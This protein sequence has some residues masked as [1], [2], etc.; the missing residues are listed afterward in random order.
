MFVLFLCV[1][2]PVILKELKQADGDFTEDQRIE[3]N[4]VRHLCVIPQTSYKLIWTLISWTQS[5]PLFN[6]LWVHLNH[7]P[8]AS[9]VVLS[10]LL[11]EEA[12][13]SCVFALH[14]ILF[15]VNLH[16]PLPTEF[17]MEIDDAILV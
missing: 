8:C 17:S 11:H 2:Q 6:L 15:H 12:E 10:C 5:T 4:T 3:L 1:F 14:L 16:K 7:P 9:F 13:K